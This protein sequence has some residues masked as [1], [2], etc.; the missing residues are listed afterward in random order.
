MILENPTNSFF[1][2]IDPS[3]FNQIQ[4]E[5]LVQQAGTLP[6]RILSNIAWKLYENPTGPILKLHLISFV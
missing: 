2:N 3:L 1:T 5:L 4:R 6:V